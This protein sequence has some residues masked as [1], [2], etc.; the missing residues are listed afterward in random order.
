MDA[1]HRLEDLADGSENV[2]P[3]PTRELSLRILLPDGSPAPVVPVRFLDTQ[4]IP[5]KSL[6]RATGGEPDAE[7]LLEVLGEERMTDGQGVVTFSFS[8]GPI[9]ASAEHSDLYGMQPFVPPAEDADEL[10]LRLQPDHSVRAAAVGPE[11]QS[12][13]GVPIALA[14]ELAS[15]GGAAHEPG[16]D[17]TASRWIDLAVRET[18]GEGATVRFRDGRG[19]V[20]A[21]S[22]GSQRFGV[23]AALPGMERSAPILFDPDL[24]PSD[25]I[26][27]RVP[28]LSTTVVEVVNATGQ[29][30]DMEA[31]VFLENSAAGA[32]APRLRARLRSGRAS[33]RAVLPE[34]LLRVTVQPL[35][36]S[37]SFEAVGPSALKAGDAVTISVTAPR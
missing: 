37:A 3:L 21:S 30:V 1:D 33:F 8:G 32:G 18:S 4:L 9:L 15:R 26:E 22:Q 17:A 19:G 35:E 12:L 14:M 29:L 23:R 11:G 31:D 10:T 7:K 2:P 5:R 13:R 25:P 34:M 28:A 16:A 6:L 36:G 24:P 27:V 20:Q